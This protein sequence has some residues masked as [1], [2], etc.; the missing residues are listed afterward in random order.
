MYT[1]AFSLVDLLTLEFVIVQSPDKMKGPVFGIMVALKGISDAMGIVQ[2]FF[3]H[4][5]CVMM[6]QCYY[7]S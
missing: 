1:V 2:Q 4:T 5:P 6:Y 7:C 3:S